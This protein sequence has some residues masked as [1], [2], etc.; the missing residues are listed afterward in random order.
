MGLIPVCCQAPARTKVR[1]PAKSFMPKAF[2]IW[3][4]QWHYFSSSLSG[5]PVNCSYVEPNGKHLFLTDNRL[6][7]GWLVVVPLA[8]AIWSRVP[9][10]REGSGKTSP[11]WA[12]GRAVMEL[13]AAFLPSPDPTLHWSSR[14]PHGVQMPSLAK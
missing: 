7:S 9:G 13:M 10:G 5:N 6:P 4:F 1:R 8:A 11:S 3:C 12:P 14:H 2:S